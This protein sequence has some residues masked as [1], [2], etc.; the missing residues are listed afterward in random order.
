MIII[1]LVVIA[2]YTCLSPIIMYSSDPDD[3]GVSGDLVDCLGLPPDEF[4]SEDLCADG[5]GEESGIR[6]RR[7]SRLRGKVA[8]IKEWPV[9][10]ILDALYDKGV[11]TPLGCS[12]EELF[13]FF[14][15]HGVTAPSVPL[16]APPGKALAKGKRDSH[17]TAV[18]PAKR[19]RIR[20][21]IPSTSAPRDPVLASLTDIQL[22]LGDMASRI[23]VLEAGVA[24]APIPTFSGLVGAPA[25]SDR[26]VVPRRSLASAVPAAAFGV[27]FLSPV[28]G[29]SLH[30]RS[31]ILTG[32]STSYRYCL[33]QPTF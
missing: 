32:M 31:Q 13:V 7:S 21:P 6:V 33:V 30:L 9:Y 15:D 27:P 11:T 3:T 28:A 17:L 8:N 18:L 14:L 22:S 29:V 10:R 24:R 1:L 16:G 20:E 19:A 23:T 5:V 12:H 26:D 2:L 4:P 25:A